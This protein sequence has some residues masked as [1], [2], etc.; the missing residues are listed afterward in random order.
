FIRQFVSNKKRDNCGCTK[1]ENVPFQ[2]PFPSR[3][4]ES[5]RTK[6]GEGRRERQSRLPSAT[7]GT[8]RIRLGRHST[9]HTTQ[10]PQSRRHLKCLAQ[11]SPHPNP[12]GP[13]RI[14]LT[15]YRSISVSPLTPRCFDL[16]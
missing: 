13:L 12:R 1:T 9:V 3:T 2:H 14:L 15:T 4:M 16:R 8:C 5:Q 11:Q 6:T 10:R 7:P